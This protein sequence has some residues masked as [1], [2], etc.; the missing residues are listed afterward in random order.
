MDV[1]LPRFAELH[2]PAATVSESSDEPTADCAGL[3]VRSSVRVSELHDA[4]VF[5]R[6]TVFELAEAFVKSLQTFGTVQRTDALRRM[7][8]KRARVHDLD[9]RSKTRVGAGT[10]AARQHDVLV[11]RNGRVLRFRDGVVAGRTREERC[12]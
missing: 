7:R 2:E 12:A 11:G 10:S 6:G 5:R 9:R 3:E 4:D 1:A 8:P